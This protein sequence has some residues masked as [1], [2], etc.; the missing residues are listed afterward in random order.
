MPTRSWRQ[1][2]LTTSRNTRSL[3]RLHQHSHSQWDNWYKISYN[4][5]TSVSFQ[6]LSFFLSKSVQSKPLKGM[7]YLNLFRWLILPVLRKCVSR[8]KAFCP[9]FFLAVT[10]LYPGVFLSCCFFLYLGVFQVWD[11]DTLSPDDFIGRVSICFNTISV[12]IWFLILILCNFAL[13]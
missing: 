9:Y 10:S 13:I 5:S 4:V 7:F 11:K 6:M 8:L 3:R 12:E 1:R 2:S